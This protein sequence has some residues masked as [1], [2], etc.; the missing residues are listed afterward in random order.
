MSPSDLDPI[1][2]PVAYDKRDGE[3]VVPAQPQDSML[4]KAIRTG[5]PIP[6][7]AKKSPATGTAADW[8]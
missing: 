6:A 8:D 5:S 4:W 1:M 2:L 3:R 7:A